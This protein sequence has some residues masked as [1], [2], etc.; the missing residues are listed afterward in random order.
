MGTTA[1]E[2][3]TILMREHEKNKWDI[4]ITLKMWWVFFSFCFVLVKLP[5]KKVHWQVI[6]KAR[7][8][9]RN[10]PAQRH[11]LKMSNIGLYFFIFIPCK[12][13]GKRG[14]NK[15]ASAKR[16]RKFCH[17]MSRL[18]NFLLLTFVLTFSRLS[19]NSVCNLASHLVRVAYP[20]HILNEFH[21]LF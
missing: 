10:G 15:H 8:M 1:K 19:S 2:S 9:C 13:R 17:W 18:Q 14:K 16:R 6:I 11:F 7:S 21:H 5:L 3:S 12:W 4:R 20:H